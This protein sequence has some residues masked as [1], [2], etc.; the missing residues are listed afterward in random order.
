M[1]THTKNSALRYARRCRPLCSPF[2]PLCVY[3]KM[4]KL[5][6]M[7]QWGILVDAQKTRGVDIDMYR[8]AEHFGLER[9]SYQTIPRFLSHM[10]RCPGV[11]KATQECA[12]DLF[13]SLLVKKRN[14]YEYAYSCTQCHWA[15]CPWDLCTALGETLE[16][17]YAR[18]NVDLPQTRRRRQRYVLQDDADERERDTKRARYLVSREESSSELI[19]DE[20]FVLATMADVI[21][22]I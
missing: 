11:S 3:K 9:V 1:S 18:F 10:R 8:L 19:D 17:V 4:D 15:A 2:I 22:C 21:E 6:L 16:Q 20:E 13:D 14:T 5:A 12:S 7:M